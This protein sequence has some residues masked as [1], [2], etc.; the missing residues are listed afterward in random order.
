LVIFNRPILYAGERQEI[1]CARHLP[2]RV[3]IEQ[4]IVFVLLGRDAASG[5]FDVAVEK[6]VIVGVADIN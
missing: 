2:A 5:G 1:F 6:I 4:K 3:G